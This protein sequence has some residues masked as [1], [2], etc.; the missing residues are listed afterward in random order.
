MPRLRVNDTELYYEDTGPGASGQC[1]LFSHGLLWS[2]EMFA[3]QIAALRNDYRV[4]SYDHR[5]QGRSAESSMRSIDMGTV[6]ADAIALI[7]ALELASVHFVGLS[8]GGFVG[9]RIAARRPELLRSLALLETSA[10]PEPD[11]N[12]ARY[13]A[14]VLA[15]RGLGNRLLAERV[16][17]IMFGQTFLGDPA[18]AAERDKWR[19]H[20][21]RNR[22]SIWRAV[23]GVLERETVYPELARIKAP[24]L[25]L[26]GDQDVAT[27]LDKSERMHAAIEGSKLT[28][29]AGAGHSSSIEQPE[30][31]NALLREHLERARSAPSPPA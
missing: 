28:V 12:I 19:Q 1:V 14:L 4:V 17:R 11:Q 22:R 18:R 25:I 10:D 23:N 26:V 27:V 15:V 30:R 24:T 8:M 21:V 29:I 7:E 6:T 5:G 9:L 3:S 20:L 2:G 13:R 16:M 31:V